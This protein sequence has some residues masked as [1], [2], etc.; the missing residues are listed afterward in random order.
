MKNLDK[1]YKKLK[2]QL[3]K[4]DELRQ[5]AITRSRSI[6]RKSGEIVR[7]LHKSENIENLFKDLQAIEKEVDKL[8]ADLKNHPSLYHSNTVEIAEQE[9]CEAYILFSILKDRSIPD[10]DKLKVTYNAYILGLADTIGE[11]RRSCL[12][13]LK[14]GNINQ[15]HEYL[16][17]MED[18]FDVLIKLDYPSGLIATRRKQDIARGVIEKTRSEIAVIASNEELKNTIKVYQKTLKK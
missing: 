16:E 13:S 5:A 7:K 18:L 11:L 8:R 4:K 6:V 14:S 10:P 9:F 2:N 12:N 17:I 1:T 15:A 3:D